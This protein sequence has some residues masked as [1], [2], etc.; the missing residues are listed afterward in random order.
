M[1]VVRI[2]DP[3]EEFKKLFKLRECV[4][5]TVHTFIME[6]ERRGSR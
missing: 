4:Q 6:A 3:R 2:L 5:A 1:N